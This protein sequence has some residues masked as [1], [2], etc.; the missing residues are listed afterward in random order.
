M[1]I[2]CFVEGQIN[3]MKKGIIIN[4]EM[5][6]HSFLGEMHTVQKYFER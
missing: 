3:I 1:Y 2:N 4:R 6:G 5:Q